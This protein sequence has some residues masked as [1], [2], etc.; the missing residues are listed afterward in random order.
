MIDVALKAFLAEVTKAGVA[1][2]GMLIEYEEVADRASFIAA[3]NVCVESAVQ[4]VRDGTPIKT[5]F[6]AST[7][8]ALLAGARLKRD[9]IL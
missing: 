3:V 2:V 4:N 6:Q 1:N 5:A 7:A 9:G 8:L